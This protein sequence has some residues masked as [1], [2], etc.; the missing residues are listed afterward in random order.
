MDPPRHPPPGGAGRAQDFYGNTW[1]YLERRW[2]LD[3]LTDE[4]PAAER[5]PLTPSGLHATPEA[6]VTG[7]SQP[8]TAPE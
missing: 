6:A 8:V 2:R 3:R 4:A 1:R 5:H 7:E